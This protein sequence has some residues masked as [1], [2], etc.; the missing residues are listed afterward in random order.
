MQFK[1]SK[2]DADISGDCNLNLEVALI[3]PNYDLHRI[4]NSALGL[5]V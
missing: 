5:F 4:E 2:T 3:F 1:A